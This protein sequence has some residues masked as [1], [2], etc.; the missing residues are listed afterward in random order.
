MLSV[1]LSESRLQ[2]IKNLKKLGRV[3]KNLNT[4]FLTT[5]LRKKAQSKDTWKFK[6]PRGLM[7]ASD[8][9]FGGR[10]VTWSDW[11]DCWSLD[12]D[13]WRASG[14]TTELAGLDP[15]S[16][17]HR[18]SPFSLSTLKSNQLKTNDF[19]WWKHNLKGQRKIV[20]CS[21]SAFALIN[22]ML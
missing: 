1:S 21:V 3:T 8:T 19:Y 7:R 2:C 10:A 14:L 12:S 5:K 4:C 18:K 16:Y 22:V 11:C 13:S 20:L 6:S 17:Q 9:V 15:R